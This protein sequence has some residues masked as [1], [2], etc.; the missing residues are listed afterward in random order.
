MISRKMKGLV[1]R[2]ANGAVHVPIGVVLTWDPDHD[3]YAVMM[4]CS[5]D[6][7]DTMS[8]EDEEVVWTFARSLLSDGLSSLAPFGQGDVKMRLASVA[9]VNLIVCLTSPE[10]H[11]DLLLPVLD[12][13]TFLDETRQHTELG[14]EDAAELVDEFL[15]EFE[16]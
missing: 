7:E 14:N 15:K 13:E 9:R 6:A 11:A 8:G 12:V 5:L 2:S 3:P 1:V 4:I 10:G 16:Q